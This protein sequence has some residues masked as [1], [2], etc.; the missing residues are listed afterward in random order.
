MG[1][2]YELALTANTVDHG[3]LAAKVASLLSEKGQPLEQP[4]I[5][6]VDTAA[7]LVRDIL[8][9]A[10][11]LTDDAYAGASAQ[12]IS[13]L[14]FALSPLERLRLHCGYANDADD[15]VIQL[16]SRIL[17]ALQRI[18]RDAVVP[19]SNENADLAESFFDFLADSLLSSLNR[20]DSSGH[21]D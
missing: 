13:S 5:S 3:V 8:A 7:D 10:R 16:L 18:K 1:S 19:L 12:G 4:N 2:S 11:T 6:V 9:G 17:E 15:I 20:Q 14:G 21:T